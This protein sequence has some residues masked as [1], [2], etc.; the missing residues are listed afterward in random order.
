MPRC[1]TIQ[2]KIILPRWLPEI[3]ILTLLSLRSTSPFTRGFE[4]EACDAVDIRPPRNSPDP[5]EPDARQ[6]FSREVAPSR[7]A[8]PLNFSAG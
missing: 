2:L 5:G 8:R 1:L 4:V 7:N 6:E 3:K